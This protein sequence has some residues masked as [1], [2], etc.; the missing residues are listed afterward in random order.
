MDRLRSTS[1]PV[2]TLSSKKFSSLTVKRQHKHASIL[3][4]N[5]IDGELDLFPLYREYESILSLPPVPQNRKPLLDRLHLHEEE[6]AIPYSLQY[7][8][9][10]GD[11]PSNTTLLEIDIY[12]DN[13]RS[14]HNIG[15]ILRTVEAFRL[16][17][18]YISKP[19]P[20]TALEKIQK[21]AMG[22][23]SIIPIHI[24]DDLSQLKRPF[25]AVE[26]EQH[27]KDCHHFTFPNSF[28]LLFG[29]EQYGL[30]DHLLSLTDDFVHIPL[31]GSKNSLN[32]SSAFAIIASCI[33]S[34]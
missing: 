23:E 18:V 12:L 2:P 20:K 34:S 21:T 29:N 14:M 32:V 4:A 17:K 30:S 15:A 1:H 11:V 6:A 3:L 9:V 25:I 13:L 31:Y 26:T 22:S 27:A 7:K 24:I 28:T 33:R 16:G 19:L 5:V 8:I 10:K